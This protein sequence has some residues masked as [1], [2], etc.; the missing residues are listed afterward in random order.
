MPGAKQF[1]MHRRTINQRSDD[2]QRI[3][4]VQQLDEAF[5]LGD[6]AMK[7]AVRKMRATC[8]MPLPAREIACGLK[9]ISH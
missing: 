1:R 5:L 3:T 8:G 7:N 2:T 9:A 4:L 6:S